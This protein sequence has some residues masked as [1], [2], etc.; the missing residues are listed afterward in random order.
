MSDAE[1]EAAAE[2]LLEAD[3]VIEEALDAELETAAAAAD[4]EDD[5]EDEVLAVMLEE[6]EV[7]AEV[8]SAVEEPVVELLPETRK[9]VP[10]GIEAPPGCVELLSPVI[11]LIVT[12][13]QVPL[14]SLAHVVSALAPTLT[15]VDPSGEEGM[16]SARTRV[17][18]AAN[19]GRAVKRDLKNI[20]GYVFVRLSFED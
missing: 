17:V 10:H 1:A 8:E 14:V 15:T 11:N 12:S 13:V 18:K 19:K 3:R 16:T 9:P 5:A 6:D 20:V 7:T 4:I 2:L